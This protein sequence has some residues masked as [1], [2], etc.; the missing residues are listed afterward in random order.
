M[1]LPLRSKPDLDILFDDG[2]DPLFDRDAVHEIFE[3][4]RS[5]LNEYNPPK[6]AVAEA[7][8]PFTDRRLKYA[9]PT[10]L[11]QAFNFNLLQ[12]PFDAAEFRSIAKKCLSEAASSGASSTWVCSNHDAVRHP[13]RYAMPDGSPREDLEAWL[14]ADGASPALDLA[15]GLRRARAATPFMLGLPGSAYLYQGEELGLFEV[16]DLPAA[17][18]QDPTWFRTGNTVK[19]RD[20]YRVPLPWSAV[21][22]NFGFGGTPWLPQPKWFGSL[23]ATAQD[24]EAGSTLEMYRSTLAW[25]S[26]LQAEETLEWLSER[27]A[28][29]VHYRR[30]NGWEVITNFGGSPAA[31]PSGVDLSKVV[32]SSGEGAAGGSGAGRATIP[33]ETTLWLA[34]NPNARAH[35]GALPDNA[36]ARPAAVDLTLAGHVPSACG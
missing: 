2:S 32:L 22:S 30:P 14:L 26:K 9:R 25:R 23:A 5:V 29:A 19:G 7:W 15:L 16:A 10:E 20:G 1:A 17:S 24:G 4:W 6:A 3:G 34:P 35:T 13:S 33:A 8:V 28:G 18:L 12:A 31:L 21:E 36:R 11:G 27:A